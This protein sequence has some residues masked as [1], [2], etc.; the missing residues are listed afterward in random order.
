MNRY[1]EIQKFLTDDELQVAEN[2]STEI[3]SFIDPNGVFKGTESAKQQWFDESTQL[4][5][6][7]VKKFK[8]IP[9]LVNN[10]ID[11]MQVAH[12]MKPYDVHGDFVVQKNQVPI[13][14]PRVNQPTYTIVIPLIDGHYHTVVFNQYTEY[15]NFSEYKKTHN[16]LETYV[17]DSIWNEHCGHCH[18]EDQRYLTVKKVINWHKGGLFAWDRS[19]FHAS[20]NYKQPRKAIVLWLSK[21]N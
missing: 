3:E 8:Q 15:N 14:D 7:I 9:E 13:S 5:K 11:G 16:I 10:K 12:M 2:T 1:F 17:D 4:G 20:G 18:K 6:L 21:S 19:L